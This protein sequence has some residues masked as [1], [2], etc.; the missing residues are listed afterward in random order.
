VTR[1]ATALDELLDRP[2]WAQRDAL[3]AGEVGV[4][5]LVTATL[6]RIEAVDADLHSFTHVDRADALAEARRLDGFRRSGAAPGPLFGVSVSVKDLFH[7]ARMPTTA[8]SLV[9]RDLVADEDS[10]HAARVRAAGAVVVGKTNTPE[11]G[12]FPRT[13]N[14]LQPETVNP[15]DRGRISGGSSGGSAASVAAGLTPIAVGSDAGGSVRI[16]AALCGVAGM[17]PSRGLVPRHG[18][19]V[20]TLLFS[21]AGPVAADV[22]DLATLLQVLAGPL[23][24]DPFAWTTRPRDVLSALDAGLAGIRVQWLATTGV[25]DVDPRVPG[26]AETAARELAAAE[27][28][29]LLPEPLELDAARWQEP[30]YAMMAADRYAAIGEPIFD[31]EERRAQ[32]SEYGRT[33]LERGRSVSGADYSRALAVRYAARAELVDLFTD[34]DLLLSPTTCVV[35]PRVSED[36]RREPLIAFTNFCNLTGLPAATVPCGLVDGLPVGLQVI[37]RPGADGLVL[38]AC[39]AFERLH[40]IER[41]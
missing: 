21:T 8:G 18:G 25:A 35:A 12:V 28:A 24:A 40:P 23:A 3:V 1:A 11:F 30:F 10:V 5:E 36:V 37:G 2:A 15:W 14:R 6:D 34:R 22:R 33:A 19:V 4:V 41:P 9:F 31:D 17:L 29:Q 27:E 13:V 38:R 39:R 26:V 16:P 7:V 20:G 32:L